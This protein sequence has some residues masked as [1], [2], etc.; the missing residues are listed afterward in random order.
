VEVRP[1]EDEGAGTAEGGSLAEGITQR[2]LPKAR[3][4]S[5]W[6]GNLLTHPATNCPTCTQLQTVSSV[7]RKH[8]ANNPT[9]PF[10]SIMGHLAI[11]LDCN[12]DPQGVAYYLLS[13]GEKKLQK[14]VAHYL[15][16]RSGPAEVAHYSVPVPKMRNKY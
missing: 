4:A 14:E 3:K 15:D 7:E 6:A 12:F 8:A 16:V 1:G 11:Y 10:S 5:W 13:E 2:R 9:S